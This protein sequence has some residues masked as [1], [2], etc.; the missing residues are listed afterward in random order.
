M[1]KQRLKLIKLIE[2]LAHLLRTNLLPEDY[3]LTMKARTARQILRQRMFFV[4]LQTMTN[5]RII[6]LLD[7]YQEKLKNYQFLKNTD[8]F[9]NKAIKLLKE[10]VFFILSEKEKHILSQDLN[11]LESLK[12][13]IKA[14]DDFFKKLREDGERISHLKTI[15]GIGNFFATLIVFEV[16]DINRFANYKK[17]HG[18][19]GLITSTYL[20][21]NR[22]FHGRLTK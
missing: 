21:G 13:R 6:T 16:D 12:E 4:R 14:S 17:F 8:I 2:A 19:M 18:Y 5:N 9:I 11:L 22:T 15:P 10:N 3:M 1:L 7:K 20:S